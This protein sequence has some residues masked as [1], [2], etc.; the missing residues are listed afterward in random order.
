MK[1]AD[2]EEPRKILSAA[3]RRAIVAKAH[4]DHF[5][6]SGT[7][8]RM[9]L[10]VMPSWIDELA[11][12]HELLEEENARLKAILRDWLAE[13]PSMCGQGDDVRARAEE[14]VK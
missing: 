1:R 8:T 10:C 14:A 6:E 12:S 4:R 3:E 5:G 13:C 7:M 9:A 11:A 2:G